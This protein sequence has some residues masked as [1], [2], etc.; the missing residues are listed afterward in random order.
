VL[1]DWG[2]CQ[3]WH[4]PLFILDRKRIFEIFV[5]IRQK[6]KDSITLTSKTT[7]NTITKEQ[8]KEIIRSTKGKFFTLVYRK[9]NGEYRKACAKA[10]S[11]NALRGGVSCHENS[12]CVIYYDVNKKEYRS[13]RPER[14]V[15]I[16]QGGKELYC[17]R[18]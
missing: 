18:N 4:V 10:F 17:N 16:N 11:I 12:G 5:D 3:W 7:M 9:A 8:V 14:L 13:F 6:M 15:S 2:A 1:N